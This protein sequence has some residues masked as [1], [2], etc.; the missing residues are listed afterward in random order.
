VQPLGSARGP[1]PG[2]SPP[3][4]HGH[5]GETGGVEAARRSLNAARQL[6]SLPVWFLPAARTCEQ[7]Q[8]GRRPFLSNV[9]TLLATTLFLLLRDLTAD[10]K[11]AGRRQLSSHG[12][13]AKEATMRGHVR[14]R[15]SW[16]VHRRRRP[17]SS[18]LAEAT[19]EQGRLRQQEGGGE[20]PARVHPTCGR[21]R[22]SLSR[23]D[24]A[25]RSPQPVARV[26]TGS[27]DASPHA[28]GLRGLHPPG[29]RPRHRPRG[30]H[31]YRRF[32]S[33]S[34]AQMD[35]GRSLY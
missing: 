33:F 15:R 8:Q 6:S 27:R 23:A 9:G 35:S 17:S 16:G 30:A 19:E 26:P 1:P 14:K 25:G 7:P 3:R 24:R 22:R 4:T 11:S 12:P 5:S 21:R 34:A 29:D 2:S 32:H 18:H 13:L 10:A 28:R 20:R 31:P